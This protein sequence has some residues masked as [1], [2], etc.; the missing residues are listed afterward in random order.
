MKDIRKKI[1]RRIVL[2]ILSKNG[3]QGLNAQITLQEIEKDFYKYKDINFF[4]KIKLYRKGFCPKYLKNYK[5]TNKEDYLNYIPLLK[6]YKLPM[7]THSAQH[8]HQAILYLPQC[9]LHE[10]NMVS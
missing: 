4:K 6:Y 2:K 9:R 1:F 7:L 10:L 8:L 3:Y 5:L